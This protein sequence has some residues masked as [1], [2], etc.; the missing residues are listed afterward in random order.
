MQTPAKEDNTGYDTS[1]AVPKVAP[2]PPSLS[3]TANLKG[4][5]SAIQSAIRDE[6]GP[7]SPRNSL[8]EVGPRLKAMPSMSLAY[9]GR[10]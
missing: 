2:S 3:L 7:F 9:G 1:D 6:T 8:P 5:V 10:S 4:R